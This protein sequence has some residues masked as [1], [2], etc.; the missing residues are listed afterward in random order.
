[1]IVVLAVALVPLRIP[2]ATVRC[3]ASAPSGRPEQRFPVASTPPEEVVAAQLLALSNNDLARVFQ[4]FSRARRRIILEAG[5]AQGGGGQLDLPESQIRRRVRSLLDESCPRLIGHGSSEII[6]G[7]TLNGRGTSGAVRTLPR[8]RCRVKV[9]T[10]YPEMYDTCDGGFLAAAAAA[11]PPSYFIFTLTRQHDPPPTPREVAAGLMWEWDQRDKARFDGNEC[12]WLVWS[13]EPER[14]GGGGS[15][16][17]PPDD[18]GDPRP[19]LALQL[20]HL[21]ARAA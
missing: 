18:G 9:E 11:Q 19:G 7:L 13:I 17:E 21:A 16:E 10:F 3:D 1:M 5:R 4:L 6:S 20:P 8:W 15:D 14:R 12:C 2:R